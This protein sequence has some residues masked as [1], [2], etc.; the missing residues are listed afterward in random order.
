MRI[1]VVEKSIKVKKLLVSHTDLDGAGSLFLAKY[2]NNKLEFTNMISRD[3]DFEKDEEDFRYLLSFDEIVIADLSISQ[4]KT[5][6]LRAKGIKVTFFDHH[7]SAEWLKDEKE[8]EYSLEHCGTYLFWNFYVKKFITDYPVIIDELISLINTYDLWQQDN[9]LWER[10][11]N[12]NNVL[13]GIKDYSQKDNFE[14]MMPFF[15]LL[16][17]KVD[18]LTSWTE[19][20]KEVILIEKAAK[21]EEE[22]YQKAIKMMKILSLIHI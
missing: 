22:M 3:Y 2:F 18:H 15:N 11:K 7:E 17:S 8:S 5:L 6:E 1:R 21:R 20:S 16:E 9:I 4:E 13:Y 10:A 12:L 14:A 19:T